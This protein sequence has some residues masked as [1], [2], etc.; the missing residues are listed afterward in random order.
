M[1]GLTAGARV[2]RGGIVYTVLRVWQE[3]RRWIQHDEDV[4][5]YITY[6]E[7]ADANGNKVTDNERNIIVL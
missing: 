3:W 7:L 4:E 6:C 2:R 1:Y 5:D